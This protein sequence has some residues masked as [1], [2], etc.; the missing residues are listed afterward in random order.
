MPQE[1]ESGVRL[2]KNG[3]L[4]IIE[5]G[6]QVILA[7]YDKTIGHL[8]FETREYSVKYYNPCVTRIGTL[9][10]DTE[11]SGNAI[12]SMGIKGIG[13]VDPK[14]LPRRP[15]LGKLG[16]S[17]A[18]IVE[19]YLKHDLAQ[20]IVRYGIFLD[21]EGKP[22]R[23]NVRRVIDTTLDLR[24]LDQEDIEWTRVG[25]KTQERNPVGRE[26]EVI[27]LKDQVIARR[28][29]Q[30]TFTPNE[31]VGGFTPDDD[32][33]NGVSFVPLTEDDGT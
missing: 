14:V 3:D 22:V 25:A 18:E 16:D 29:T 5:E 26:R 12:L 11:V 27:E 2:R 30:G 28:A 33:E 7:H 9:P 21:A 19:W 13:R 8:E 23:K 31:V 32:E 17:A 4:Y 24:N 10:G 15:R 20:A 1:T 6:H